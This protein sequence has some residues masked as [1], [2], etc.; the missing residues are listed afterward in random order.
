MSGALERECP[1]M[2]RVVALPPGGDEVAGKA[3]LKRQVAKQREEVLGR[4]RP[5]AAKQNEVIVSPTP[6]ESRVLLPGHREIIGGLDQGRHWLNRGGC[7]IDAGPA[8][9]RIG[10]RK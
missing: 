8:G 9:R 5:A 2:H 6:L 10:G 1:A 4:G 7:I 3:A